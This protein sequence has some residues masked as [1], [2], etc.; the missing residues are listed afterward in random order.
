MTFHWPEEDKRAL[1]E[2]LDIYNGAFERAAVW[3][4][5]K[6]DELAGSLIPEPNNLL[7]LLGRLI[8]DGEDEEPLLIK[9]LKELE[10][11]VDPATVRENATQW[12]DALKRR[13]T[14]GWLVF[15]DCPGF[16]GD[17][18]G[19]TVTV[20]VAVTIAVAGAN[21]HVLKTAGPSD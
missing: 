3:I 16:E 8:E 13:A 1:R 2:A 11:R 14:D 12:L 10:G 15:Y 17:V 4:E 19:V 18:G 9:V 5:A 7:K 21:A 20:P 6:G